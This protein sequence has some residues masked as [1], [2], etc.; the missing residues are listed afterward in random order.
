MDYTEHIKS[1]EE[2][3]NM[4]YENARNFVKMGRSKEEIRVCVLGLL[5]A[6]NELLKIFKEVHQASEKVYDSRMTMLKQA[7]I[8]HKNEQV[9]KHQEDYLFKFVKVSQDLYENGVTND[10]RRAFELPIKIDVAESIPA[11]IVDSGSKLDEKVKNPIMTDT[12]ASDDAQGWGEMLFEKYSRSVVEI[13]AFGI[14]AGYSG[15]GFVISTDGSMGG[16]PCG[17]ILT[18]DHVV[19]DHNGGGYCDK[20][21]FGLNE[22]TKTG[23]PKFRSYKCQLLATSQKYDIALLSFDSKNIPNLNSIPFISDY[24]TLKQGADCLIIGNAFG[25]GLAPVSGMVKFTHEPQ[26]QNLIYTSPSNNQGDS[27]APIF[28]RKGECIGINKSSITS[29]NSIQATGI[30][31]ATPADKIQEYLKKWES[32]HGIEF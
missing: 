25:M 10:V 15:T 3:Q 30:Q 8:R 5:N 12:L 27:G 18:N 7:E 28:N 1:Y 24:S 23:K 29:I 26:T 20:I 6:G 11:T 31:N 21:A 9:V 13:C 22:E 2:Q 16:D 4:C 32:E 14:E 17:F 19:Y